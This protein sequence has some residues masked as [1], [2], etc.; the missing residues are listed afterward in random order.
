MA[1]TT[2]T[3]TGVAAVYN[4]LFGQPELIGFVQNASGLSLTGSYFNYV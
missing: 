3:I 4:N 2:L 1:S